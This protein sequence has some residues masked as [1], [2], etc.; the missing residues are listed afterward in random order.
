MRR[1]Q[2]FEFNERPETPAF[3]RDAIT[4]ILGTVWRVIQI[5]NPVGPVFAE[6]CEK[7]GCRKVLDLASGS[8]EPASIL[9]DGLLREGD[10]SV[11]MIL[12]DLFPKV[13]P[14]ER[15]AAR[16]PGRIDVAPSPVDASD[17]PEEIKCDACSIVG[18]FHHFSPDLAARILSDC[19]KKKRAVFIL[20]V[21]ARSIWRFLLFFPLP[22]LL[23]MTLNPLLA[24]EARLRKALFTYLV[25][26]I[27]A[28]GT[29]D[30]LVS[31][32]RFY[33]EDEYRE[34]AGRAGGAY[35]WEYR[36][37]TFFPGGSL[38][39]FQGIPKPS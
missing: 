38:A 7:A 10:S 26:A 2:A 30:F 5:L 22:G 39:V 6:F 9:V 25:P 34:M 17:V 24:R 15:V 19:V 32:L 23:A 12:S 33:S 27:P 35:R 37:F 36:E 16:Y 29:W 1:I 14:M 18:A 28:M 4:E 11:R 21:P 3:I 13:G 31:A 20:D 8:G